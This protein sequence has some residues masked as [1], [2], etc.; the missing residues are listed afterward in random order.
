MAEDDI[1][2]EAK[3]RLISRLECQPSGTTDL[4]DEVV[5]TRPLSSKEVLGV[6]GRDDFPFL[7]GNEVLMQA[8][9]RGSEGQA[10][11]LAK[12]SF[13]GSLEDV[14][15]MP[16]VDN[17]QRAVLVSTINV[18]LKHIGPHRWHCALQGWRP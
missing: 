15:E 2:T 14:L 7:R 5:V 1:L 4:N 6:T 16:L 12:G 8:I 3:K 13:S 17:F 18:V 9:Y 10:F 11:T